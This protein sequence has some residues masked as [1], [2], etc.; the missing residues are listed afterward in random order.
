MKSKPTL[1][2]SKNE[3]Q[4]PN[5]HAGYCGGYPLVGSRA[6]TE[7]RA[8]PGSPGESSCNA[9]GCH[10]G[11]TI[12]AAGGSITIAAPTMPGWRYV[13]GQ[14]YP[15]SVTVERSGRSLFGI[16]FEAL[17][18]TGANGGTL[19]IT[20]SSQTQIKSKTVSGNTRS[21]VVHQLN[22]GAS[23]NT[24]TFTFNWT[25]PAASIG[26]VTFYA[27]GNAADGDGN[28]SGD[29]IYKTSQA[30]TPI[31]TGLENLEG[32]GAMVKVFPIP[33]SDHFTVDFSL[34]EAGSVEMN[35]TSLEGKLC[36]KII[37]GTMSPGEHEVNYQVPGELRKGN[38][39]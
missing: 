39:L 26:T 36:S 34:S 25:A 13:P 30:V 15:I 31:T 6:T 22:G 4:I 17:R 7:R 3:K 12:N 1:I 32:I 38:Y 35:L 37:S 20:N 9:S 2:N 33:A 29:F 10:T 23:Q 11:N 5:L 19:A 16:G 14:V 27:S 21:N 18:S 24:H 8:T 28:E